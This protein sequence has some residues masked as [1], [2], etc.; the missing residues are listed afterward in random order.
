M[1]L[2]KT[3]HLILLSLIPL[4]GF[5]QVKNSQY[6]DSGNKIRLGFQ[7]TGDGLIWRDT[8]PKVPYYQPINNKAAWIV[9]DT[10]YNKF[11]HYKDS[12]WTL[13]GG[14]DIDT[15]TMLL[16][17]YR[18][19]RALGTP[20][21]GVLTNATGLPL[22]TGVTGTLGGANGGTNL[23]TFTAVGRIPYASST[24][25]L[26]TNSNLLY[27]GTRLRTNQI[28][29]GDTASSTSG[30]TNLLALSG[31]SGGGF[32]LKSSFYTPTL[33]S[34]TF[35]VNAVGN[36][37]FWNNN[38][39]SYAYLINNSNNFL[40][41][42]NVGPSE[43]LH[44][45]GNARI[46]GNIGA[47]I[48]VATAR[49]H[50][51]GVDVAANNFALKVDDS[52]G[53]NLLSV[54]NNGDV[55]LKNPLTVANGGTGATTFTAA[56]RIPYA[57]S[58]TALTTNSNFKF[59]GDIL[60]IPSAIF[61]GGT[62][63]GYTFAAKAL[64]SSSGAGIF[65][66]GAQDADTTLP[67]TFGYPYVNIGGSENRLN[68]IQTIGFGFTNGD[69]F[70]PA[71][72]GYI[73]NSVSGNTNGHLVFATRASTLNVAPDEKMR[74]KSNGNVGIG[75]ASP[76]NLLHLYGT[77]GNSYLR[78]TSNVA[79]TGSRIGLNGLTLFIDQQQNS[80]I[81][82]RT[83]S[84]ER[85]RITSGGNVGI[86]TT[87]SPQTS[88]QSQLHI[89][90]SSGT[91]TL[92]LHGTRTADGS[93]GVLNFSNITDITGGYIIGSIGVD[94][95]GFD[96]GGAMIFSTANGASTPTERMRIT[97]TGNVGIGADGS[98][99]Y[100]LDVNGTGRFSSTVNI[101]ANTSAQNLL[102]QGR[103]EDN[104]GQ[105]L[106]Y[107]NNGLTRYGYLQ[108]GS[109]YGGTVALVGDGGGRIDLD[110]RGLNVTGAGRFSG[111]G[112]N[113]PTLKIQAPIYPFIDLIIDNTNTYARNWRLAGVY[114]AYGTFEILSSTTQGDVP[115][116]SRFSING[117]T[118]AVTINNLGTGTVY[119]N[120]GVLSNTPPSDERLKNNITNISWGLNDILKLRPVS[121]NWKDDRANQGK[122]FGFIAQEVHSI[123]PEAI[124]IFGEDFKYLGLEKDAIYA[125]LVKA[126]QELSA[127]IDILKQE[128]INLKNK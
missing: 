104:Y 22:T 126:V 66:R 69:Y 118:G 15:A 122:Q 52:G 11:Y 1:M 27:D 64:T 88:P 110:N 92:R 4:L 127:E 97:N 18:S 76:E 103:E 117:V 120:S 56:S 37:G 84:T 35:L 17:Y 8:Q 40:G 54:K 20:S 53:T 106:F 98:A 3:F 68:A 29:I 121:F 50:V 58:A 43:R 109:T 9:L 23:T 38:L 10:V 7:T 111:G 128:I 108:S 24:T 95:S 114:S 80:D 46:T 102:M 48:D 125:T 93:V 45:T 72:I 116:T 31:S 6:P 87:S 112:L 91:A 32:T 90:N 75:T 21:S 30:V 63:Y 41:L 44:V 57:L 124:K 12:T 73:T 82:F 25:A 67:I 77:D 113:D 19:G 107:S 59:E 99:G 26:T 83:N 55:T 115:T 89:Y 70:P 65:I 78:W 39:E 28:A 42:G 101:V 62:N 74:I 51:K 96:N 49:L 36:A 47:G 16:P 81:I 105:I 61:N 60:Y 13:A 85:M 5:S 2:N 86:G 123:M 71:E 14:Q 94:R 100:K 79:S 33:R 119:S 34:F